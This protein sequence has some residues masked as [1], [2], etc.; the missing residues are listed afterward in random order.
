MHGIRRD[1]SK[2]I[3]HCTSDLHPGPLTYQLMKKHKC[4][5]SNAAICGLYLPLN[6]GSR[7]KGQRKNGYSGEKKQNQE[8]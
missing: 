6:T 7:K 1:K 4:I 2:I 8:K 3:A 5:K